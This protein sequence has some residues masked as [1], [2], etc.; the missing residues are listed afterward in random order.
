MFI[1]MAIGV[2]LPRVV[3]EACVWAIEAVVASY[4]VLASCLVRVQDQ[5][6]KMARKWEKDGPNHKHL[7]SKKDMLLA[8]AHS[9][10]RPKIPYALL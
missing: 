6:A 5:V 1:A 10:V 7:R 4:F 8:H 9:T 2:H 3:S